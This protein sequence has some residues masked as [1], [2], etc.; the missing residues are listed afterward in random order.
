MKHKPMPFDVTACVERNKDVAI[1]NFGDRL[2]ENR[3]IIGT[4]YYFDEFWRLRSR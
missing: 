3:N 4:K 1:A 2:D